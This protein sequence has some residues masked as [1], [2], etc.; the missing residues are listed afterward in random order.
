MLSQRLATAI[1]E[2]ADA[3]RSLAV[4][5][6]DLLQQIFKKGRSE[7]IPVPSQQELE[8]KKANLI[9]TSLVN[10]QKEIGRLL[11]VTNKLLKENDWGSP[12]SKTRAA[13]REIASVEVPS[14]PKPE[15]QKSKGRQV[16]KATL[17][18]SLSYTLHKAKRNVRAAAV[19]S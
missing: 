5:R 18:R 19:P 3:Y 4:N 6:K 16:R 17:R 8:E 11:S 15:K 10:H 1:S 9:S 13:M 14:E 2:L 12:E 7:S